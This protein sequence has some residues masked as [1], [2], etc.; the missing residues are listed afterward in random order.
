MAAAARLGSRSCD[1][2]GRELLPFVLLRVLGVAIA[3]QGAAK[4][5]VAGF[6]GGCSGKK[7]RKKVAVD[8]GCVRVRLRRGAA[9]VGAAEQRRNCSCC[10][11]VLF[12]EAC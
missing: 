3:A 12:L 6:A 8:L 1:A 10:S 9:V 4:E 7:R 5:G 11:L 2:A